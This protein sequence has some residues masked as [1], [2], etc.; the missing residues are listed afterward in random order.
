MTSVPPQRAG[1]ASGIMSAQRAIGSTIGFAVLGSVLAAWLAAT[2]EPDLATVRHQSGRA[3]GHRE[4]DRRSANP[5]AHVAEIG[6]RQPIA[7]P[8][9]ATRAAILAV[10]ERD[11]VQGIRAGLS[12]AIGAAGARPGRRMALLSA[13]RRDADR[14]ANARPRSS[15]ARS[16]STVVTSIGGLAMQRSTIARR[17]PSSIVVGACA[18]TGPGGWTTLV[19]GTSGLDNFNRVGEA[20]WSGDRRRDPGDPGRQ[21][22]GL[23][24][25]QD[26]RTPT[27]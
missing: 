20:N 24:R 16:N 6:P 12:V 19:D 9:P 27:S 18:T 26:A 15:R 1:M 14:R 21:G 22:P 11:F 8:D 25:H 10:A 7:H 23:P 13:R 17:S 5:R 3:P 4:H 2:L